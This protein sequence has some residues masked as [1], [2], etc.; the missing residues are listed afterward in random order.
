MQKLAWLINSFAHGLLLLLLVVSV[1][2][3]FERKIVLKLLMNFGVAHFLHSSVN[4]LPISIQSMP[5]TETIK[6]N[7]AT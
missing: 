1:L 4:S 2:F 7:Y 6:L 3:E 5:S